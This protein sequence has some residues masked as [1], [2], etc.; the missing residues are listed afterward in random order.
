MVADKP[1]G[2]PVAFL[3][4]ALLPIWVIFLFLTLKRNAPHTISRVWQMAITIVI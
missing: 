1:A 2:A 4:L 3:A